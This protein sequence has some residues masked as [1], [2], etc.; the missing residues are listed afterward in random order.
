MCSWKGK[1]VPGNGE[2]RGGWG[3]WLGGWGGWGGV[4]RAPSAAPGNNKIQLHTNVP[5]RQKRH[6]EVCLVSTDFKLLIHSSISFRFS[7]HR[8][9]ERKGVI[10][11]DNTITQLGH[12]FAT[13][14]TDIGL[15]FHCRLEGG[16]RHF[17]YISKTTNVI[18]FWSSQGNQLPLVWSSETS[19][20]RFWTTNSVF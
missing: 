2:E 9:S 20:L 1:E 18:D 15:T 16:R 17:K 5:W 13:D 4:R 19:Y 3:W 11:C 8:I 6:T 7:A 14:C 10:T 12:S